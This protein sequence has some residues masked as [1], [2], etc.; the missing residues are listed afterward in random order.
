MYNTADNL[1]DLDII[2][3]LLSFDTV[4]GIEEHHQIFEERFKDAD[5]R[6]DVRDFSEVDKIKALLLPLGY[7]AYLVDDEDT[8]VKISNEADKNDSDDEKI[9]QVILNT[10]ISGLSRD[11]AI[12]K[13]KN[14]VDSLFE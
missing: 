13:L 8:V 9:K 2:E 3:E 6:I 10:D 12:K 5:Y 14:A 1:E 4:C 7:E 11:D